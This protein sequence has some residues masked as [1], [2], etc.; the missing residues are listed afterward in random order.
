MKKLSLV[1][2]LF[3]LATQSYAASIQESCEPKSFFSLKESWY[4]KPIANLP[5]GQ[6]GTFFYLNNEIRAVSLAVIKNHA[7]E[8]NGLPVVHG[9]DTQNYILNHSADSNCD[10]WT[11]LSVTH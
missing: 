1:I 7:I 8:I 5:P 10:Y 4:E 3:G 9:L 6:K 2:F 11:G